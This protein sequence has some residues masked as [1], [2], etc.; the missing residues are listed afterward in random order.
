MRVV[1]TAVVA[2]LALVAAG[3]AE[4]QA[5]G[6]GDSPDAPVGAPAQTSPTAP[7]DPARCRR[8]SRDLVGRR[9]ARAER[10]ARTAGCVLRVVSRDGEDLLVTEDFSASRIN[11]AVRSGTVTEVVGL[12]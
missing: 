11:V 4:E 8:V 9:L 3:C 10:M 5:A 7:D 12:Y 6:S 2:A 1:I